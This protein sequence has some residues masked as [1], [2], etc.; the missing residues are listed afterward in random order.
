MPAENSFP[1]VA[2]QLAVI[3]RHAEEVIPEEELARKLERSRREG[4]PLVVK[5]GYDPTRPDLHLGHAVTLRKLRDFYELGHEVTF[6]IG[7]FTGLIGDPSG[8][9]ATRPA[10]SREEI[11]ANAITFRDQVS[12]VLD[13]ART[14]IR[15][16]SEWLGQFGFEEVLRLAARYTVA[17][18][19]ER[20]DFRK[21]YESEAPIAI[22]ELLYP[23][24]Q[25]YDS[26]ALR[27]DVEL[28]GTDQK[29]NLLVARDI[30]REYG[31]EPQV[32]VTLPLL[33]GTDGVQKMSKSLDNY[34]GLTEPPEEMYGKTM[35]IPDELIVKYFRLALG[36]PEAELEAIER[37]LAGGL[38]PGVVKRRLARAIVATYHDESAAA[39]AEEHFDRLFVRHEL[40]EEMPEVTV[41]VDGDGAPLAWL[42]RE[43]GL[44]AS[45]SEGRRLVEQGGVSVDEERITDPAHRVPAG[46]TVV[47]QAGKRRFARVTL[48]R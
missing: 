41:A 39:R 6:L 19:L 27:A 43:A 5:C 16:N 3:R 22:H 37:D 32:I 48:R 21:R 7:D 12:R 1:P 44:A 18:M 35:S 15:Y 24:M 8:R 4:R 47:L 26:V 14:K 29:F 30:Q 33:E 9:S 38:N 36:A 17:R 46:A 20:D 34:I 11:E 10:L 42:L 2:E 45:T 31:L 25:G 13:P 23:L 28:G 40:P